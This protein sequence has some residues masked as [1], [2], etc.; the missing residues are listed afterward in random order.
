[1]L[2]KS[3][4]SFFGFHI[5][6][7]VITAV[8]ILQAN[9]ITGPVCANAA[10]ARTTVN[11]KVITP[12]TLQNFISGIPVKLGGLT[13]SQGAF[14]DLTALTLNG[15]CIA[16]GQDILDGVSTQKVVTPATL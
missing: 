7:M 14:T 5:G 8:D 11:N 13:P 9:S 6:T 1:M 16:S 3:F 2:Q 4:S 10:E 12:A 15:G